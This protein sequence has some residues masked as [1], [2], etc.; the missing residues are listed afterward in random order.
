MP[1]SLIVFSVVALSF[2]LTLDPTTQMIVPASCTWM[3]SAPGGITAHRSPRNFT[4]S[5]S[6]WF[7]LD[8]PTTAGRSRFVTRDPLRL[9]SRHR[10][11]PVKVKGLNTN[12]FTDRPSRSREP[13]IPVRRP[14]RQG[15]AAVADWL[16]DASTQSG[17]PP[18]DG[19]SARLRVAACRGTRS[20]AHPA[21]W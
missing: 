13:L 6:R 8:L 5:S 16:V 3:L 11:T 9:A 10:A 15:F 17:G 20:T 19:G 18:N 2:C 7:S 21:G 12:R 1:P 14:A 4:M